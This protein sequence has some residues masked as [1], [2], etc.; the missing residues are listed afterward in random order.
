VREWVW[1]GGHLVSLFGLEGR[2]APELHFL[3]L[4]HLGPPGVAFELVE[5][6]GS[7]L[8][9]RFGQGVKGDRTTHWLEAEQLLAHLVKSVVVGLGNSQQTQSR[10]LPNIRFD[11]FFREALVQI[12]QAH[13]A[14]RNNSIHSIKSTA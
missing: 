3:E 13:L 5:S 1:E 7:L 9:E 12:L 4:E 8:Q 14:N 11:F 10:E 2:V 6:A